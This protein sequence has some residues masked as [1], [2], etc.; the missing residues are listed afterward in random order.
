M[1]NYFWATG[2]KNRIRCDSALLIHPQCLILLLLTAAAACPWR[3]LD[4]FFLHGELR[5]QELRTMGVIVFARGHF[6]GCWGVSVCQCI[7]SSHHSN[8]PKECV[9]LRHKAALCGESVGTKRPNLISFHL[10]LP[11]RLSLHLFFHEC[12][13]KKK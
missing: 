7:I 10:G 6:S 3:T 13:P 12:F 1:G 9:L 2:T 4:S 8:E 11:L 5:G